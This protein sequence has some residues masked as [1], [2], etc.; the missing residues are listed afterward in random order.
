M[1]DMTA[2]HTK[3]TDQIRTGH[4]CIAALDQSGGSTPKALKAYGV[5]EDAYANDG[6]MFDL[7]HAMRTRIVNAPDFNGDK[8]IGAVLFEMTMDR[9]IG[10]KPAAAAL[11]EDRGVVPFLKIDKGLEDETN[12]VQLMKAIPNLDHLLAGAVDQG[13][14][15]TKERSV[16]H[17]AN[18]TGIDAIVAQ[19]FELG[20]QVTAHGLMPILEPEVDITITN[21]AQA[22]DM[23][24]DVL[25]HHLNALPDGQQI[26]LKLTL[27]ETAGQ[28]QTVV[29]HP[30]CLKVVALSGGY[31]RDEANARLAENAGVIASFSRALIEGLSA[32]QS[33]AEFNATIGRTIDSIY[34]ASIA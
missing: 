14:F 32:R 15:G 2:L 6:E 19:Q 7:I 10:G 29:D 1:L 20:A 18:K 3:M 22:E 8:V 31:T 26:M 12:G 13:V 33:D 21:K 11:W 5:P 17:A 9:D 30:A 25:L 24:R 27:P 28:Y 4:G 16:I 34:A 23:L